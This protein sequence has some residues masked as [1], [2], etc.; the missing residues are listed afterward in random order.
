LPAIRYTFPDREPWDMPPNRSCVLD[1][2]DEG[3]HTLEEIGEFT[4]V[5]RERAR[6]VELD[7]VQQLK[8]RLS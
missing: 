6:Q 2:A 1:I 7:A 8:R 5:S 3:P 4:N